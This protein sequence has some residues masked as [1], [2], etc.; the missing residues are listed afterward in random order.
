V[1][2][3]IF[4]L[5]SAIVWLPYGVFC[6]LQPGYLEGAAGISAAAA[7]GTIE[8]RAMYGGLQAAIGALALL[9]ARRPAFAR[10]GLVTLAF[11]CAGLGGA[12]LLA[13]VAAAEASGYTAVALGFEW[14]SAGVAVWRLTREAGAAAA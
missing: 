8:L 11:L 14:M 13:T 10:A 7:T 5:L 3:R 2:S 4:L 1:P 9:G 12:R 6:F